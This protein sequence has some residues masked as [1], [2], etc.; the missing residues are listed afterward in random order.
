MNK[1]L[2]KELR[3]LLLPASVAAAAAIA[4]LA[5]TTFRPDAMGE[6]WEFFLGLLSFVFLG[7]IG[8]VAAVPFGAEFQQRTLPLVLSQPFE[9]IQLWAEKL[10]ALVMVL[11]V[12]GFLQFSVNNI[13]GGSMTRWRFTPHEEVLFGMFLLAS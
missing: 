7:S 8:L 12:L 13:L 2:L 4:P 5:F 3:P 1:R 6:A 11:V 9:R 10:L